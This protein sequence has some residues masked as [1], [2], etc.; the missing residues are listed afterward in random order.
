M[1]K[2]KII[3]LTIIGLLN[4]ITLSSQTKIIA[5]QGEYIEAINYGEKPELKRFLQQELNYPENAYKNKIEGTVELSFI[6]DAK[7]GLASSFRAL[8]T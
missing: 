4:T 8:N 7:T 1:L 5:N 3:F 6:V 2:I